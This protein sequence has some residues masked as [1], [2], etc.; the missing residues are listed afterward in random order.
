MDCERALDTVMR[1]ADVDL[2]QI[3]DYREALEH[4]RSCPSCSRTARGAARLAR[5]P[6]PVAPDGLADS[7]LAAVEMERGAQDAERLAQATAAQ[8]VAD[9]TPLPVAR[10]IPGWVPWATAAGAVAAVLVGMFVVAG[11][12]L[13]Y[14]GTGTES[15]DVAM[16]VPGPEAATGDQAREPAAG[17]AAEAETAESTAPEEAPGFVV[18]DGRVWRIL[19]GTTPDRS[20]LETQ[21]TV[22]T[23]LGSGRSG[24]RTVLTSRDNPS[25]IAV[26]DKDGSLTTF[27]LVKRLYH[28]D[29]FVLVADRAIKRFGEW[30]E[31][32]SR[33]PSPVAADGSPTFAAADPDDMGVPVYPRTGTDPE[34]GFAIA[35]GTPISDPAAGNPNWTWW[36][37][38]K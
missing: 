28:G 35:P 1:A 33:I 34:A 7:V 10:R 36:T 17:M 6:G 18:Y 26:A 9:V 14:L 19:E 2:S 16:T 27:T 23:D 22:T 31:L 25:S 13:R 24:R 5:I 29:T 12:G 37:P 8:A 20:T 38:A 15:G 30:P 11:I 3:E 32:P 4:C 21:G